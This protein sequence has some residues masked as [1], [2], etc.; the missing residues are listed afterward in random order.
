MESFFIINIVNQYVSFVLLIKVMINSFMSQFV[1][2]AHF[3]TTDC[4]LVPQS[5]DCTAIIKQCQTNL[6]ATPLQS[7]SCNREAQHFTPV[8]MTLLP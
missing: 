4:Y 8:A 6:C 7:N 2:F 5:S 3:Y 1:F